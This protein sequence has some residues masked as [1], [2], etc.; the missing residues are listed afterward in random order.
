M[1]PAPSMSSA[2]IGSLEYL[3]EASRRGNL[4]A[5]EEYIAQ[6][7]EVAPALLATL[8]KLHD[9]NTELKLLNEMLATEIEQLEER[10]RHV[11]T[12]L[13]VQRNVRERDEAARNIRRRSEVR[14]LHPF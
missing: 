6:L 1:Q 9:E 4:I 7:V 5:R 13:E 8:T 14:A 11:E 10:C 2:I 3:A 12:A